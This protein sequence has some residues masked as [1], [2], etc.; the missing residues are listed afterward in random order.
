MS[1]QDLIKKLPSKFAAGINKKYSELSDDEKP[2]FEEKLTTAT[3]RYSKENVSRDNP[4]TDPMLLQ[5]QEDAKKKSTFKSNNPYWN[6][7][8]GVF[9]WKDVYKNSK[10]Q[11]YYF[12]GNGWAAIIKGWTFKPDWVLIPKKEPVTNDIPTGDTKTPKTPDTGDIPIDTGDIP[13]DTKDIPIDTKD[14]PTPT[15]TK[16]N[17][18]YRDDWVPIDERWLPVWKPIYDSKT[19]LRTWGKKTWTWA[20][21]HS[22]GFNKDDE[23]LVTANPIWNWTKWIPTP[24]KMSAVETLWWAT[25]E[26]SKLPWKLLDKWSALVEQFMWWIFKSLFP[27][28]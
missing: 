23:A 16:D 3:D 28:N 17:T 8:V 20:N 24:D 18:K 21:P 2:A 13:I 4:G 11:N 5:Q 1:I 7:K 6:K 26:G 15:N 27:K 12:T 10:W 25:W 14:T 22:E 9:K 19:G